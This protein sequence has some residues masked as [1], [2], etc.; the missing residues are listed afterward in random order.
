MNFAYTFSGI[1]YL[2]AGLFVNAN[3]TEIVLTTSE[4]R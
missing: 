4:N 3:E 2:Y 1:I